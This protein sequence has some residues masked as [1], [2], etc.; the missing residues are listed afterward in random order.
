MMNSVNIIGNLGSDPE[1]KTFDSGK[2]VARFSVAINTYSKKDDAEPVWVTCEA[3]NEAVDRLQ[4]CNVLEGTQIAVTGM[5]ALNSYT[6]TVGSQSFKQKKLY[7]KVLSFQV[8]GAPKS[9]EP[10]EDA[11]DDAPMSEEAAEG[12]PKSE[13]PA[14]G[15]A[16]LPR[17]GRA[18]KR[19]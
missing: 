11:A 15:A 13:E 10:A 4:K 12:S 7:V 6:R 1:I 14:E 16:E 5:L 2:R 18:R 17:V 3:W 8:L 9:E 19:A